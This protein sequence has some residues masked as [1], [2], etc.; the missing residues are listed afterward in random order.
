[1]KILG[2]I[3]LSVTIIFFVFQL[4]S[5]SSNKSIEKYPYSLIKKHDGFEI[6]SYE[7][8]L[9]S[10]VK[11]P[12]DKYEDISRQGFSA[13]A[14]YI[15]GGNKKKQ[16]ISMTSPVTMALEDSITMMFMVPEK[17]NLENLPHPNNS[18]IKFKLEPAKKVAVIQFGGWAN[19]EKIETY[20]EKL[21]QM[22]NI[23]KIEYLERFHFLGYNPPYEVLS[24]KNEIMVELEINSEN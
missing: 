4:Y 14:G 2:V 6:R 15:F 19:S 13:L 18:D 9:F 21:I 1:M 8:R 16:N 12:S 17:Y 5:I 24:R 23:E 10:T 20:K 3:T 7:S 11:L 22:L